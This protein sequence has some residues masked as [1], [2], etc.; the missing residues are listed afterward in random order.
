MGE[1]RGM[2]EQGRLIMDI[3]PLDNLFKMYVSNDIEKWRHDTFFSKE[4]ETIKWLDS[5]RN[6]C[7][8][9]DIGA[10]IGIYSLYLASKKDAAQIYIFEPQR[11][12]FDRALENMRLN[13]WRRWQPTSV[14]AVS[15]YNGW[16]DFT[17]GSNLPGANDGRIGKP[18]DKSKL[19]YQVPVYCI[20]EL[21]RWLS[22]TPQHIKIDV[23]GGEAA[24]IEGADAT[25]R[26]P[27]LRSVLIEINDDREMIIDAFLSRGFTMENEFNGMTPHSRERR[28]KEEGN[29]AENVVF[30]R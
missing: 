25:L 12:N 8:F 7:I 14:C 4:P 9:W 24:I 13:G 21:C 3:T 15:N 1:Y 27:L 11:T 17:P 26:N 28:E 23:D 19:T 30:T 2:Y 18:V 10:N 5:F 16:A 29:T 22:P 20:D 6:G